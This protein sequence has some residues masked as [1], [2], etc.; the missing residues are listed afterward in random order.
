MKGR[1]RKCWRRKAV[2]EDEDADNKTILFYHLYIC[3]L[4]SERV[5]ATLINNGNLKLNT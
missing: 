1:I 2:D 3:R 4:Q 5:V